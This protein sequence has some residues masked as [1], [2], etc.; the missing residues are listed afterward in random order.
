MSKKTCFMIFIASLVIILTSYVLH[1][2]VVTKE[3]GRVFAQMQSIYIALS[4]VIIALI[5]A[6]TKHYWLLML[7]IAVVVAAVVQ[8]LVLGGALMT[9]ALLYK[10]IAFLV[11]AYLVML[12]R[13]ML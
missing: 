6:K 7:G 4:A 13:Y 1:F 5:L 3:V 2:S 8:V 9:V 11:Y 12:V 10:V